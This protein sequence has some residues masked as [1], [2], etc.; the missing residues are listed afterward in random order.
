MSDGQVQYDRLLVG[1]NHGRQISA[2]EGESVVMEMG[3][4]K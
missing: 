3:P 4:K 2:T 1:V